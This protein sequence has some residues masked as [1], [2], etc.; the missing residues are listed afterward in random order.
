MRLLG[1]TWCLG[2]GPVSVTQHQFGEKN[3]FDDQKL[4]SGKAE[5]TRKPLKMQFDWARKTKVREYLAKPDPLSLKEEGFD[6][7]YRLNDT[8]C[9][10][11]PYAITPFWETSSWGGTSVTGS[12]QF[13][14]SS[15]SSSSSTSSASS[16]VKDAVSPHCTSNP[17][18][19]LGLVDRDLEQLLSA[20]HMLASAAPASPA[21]SSVG[22]GS[23]AASVGV[24]FAGS[25]LESSALYLQQQ[26]QRVEDLMTKLVSKR[27]A[28]SHPNGTAL[29]STLRVKISPVSQVVGTQ[30]SGE[31]TTQMECDSHA[32]QSLCQDGLHLQAS[33][34]EFPDGISFSVP[35]VGL[36]NL[37]STCYM[38]SVVQC[39][40]ADPSLSQM[41]LHW[42]PENSQGVDPV[43]LKICAELQ[44]IVAAMH[45]SLR[46]S[47]S[48]SALAQ[49]ANIDTKIQQDPHEFY[50]LLSHVVEGIFS[51]SPGDKERISSLI[52]GDMEYV[53]RCTVC[54]ESSLQREPFFEIKLC[55]TKSNTIGDCIKE[56]FSEEAIPGDYRFDRCKCPNLGQIRRVAR[57]TRFPEILNL[58]LVRFSFSSLSRS[59][60]KIMN[61]IAYPGFIDTKALF[62]QGDSAAVHAIYKLFAVV[63]H[64]GKSAQGG[65][66]ITFLLDSKTSHWWQ[67][68]DST[69]TECAGFPP[70]NSLRNETPY[71]LLYHLKET[72]TTTTPFCQAVSEV[73]KEN[74]SLVTQMQE[75]ASLELKEKRA[76]ENCLDNL[77]SCLEGLAAPNTRDYRWISTPWLSSWLNGHSDISPIDNKPLLC[78]HNKVS[79]G[80]H[81]APLRKRIT[82]NMWTFLH[83][84]YN[85]GPELSHDQCCVECLQA[86]LGKKAAS[87]AYK[88]KKSALSATLS[89]CEYG[90]PPRD[91]FYISKKFIDD[92][93]KSRFGARFP[94]QG[95]TAN[96][97]CPHK[98]L[99]PNAKSAYLPVPLDIWQ[100][101]VDLCEG[102][103]PVTL[104]IAN[105]ECAECI[106]ENKLTAEELVKERELIGEMIKHPNDLRLDV[107]YSLLPTEWYVS[108]RSYVTGQSTTK[109]GPLDF[110]CLLCP[111]GKVTMNIPKFVFW[112]MK[113][114]SNYTACSP[115]QL[116]SNEAF[117]RLSTKYGQKGTAISF[118]CQE[119]NQT[120]P[121]NIHSFEPDLLEYTSTP[122][123]CLPCATNYQT[124][125][126]IERAQFSCQD[127]LVKRISRSRLMGWYNSFV[128]YSSAYVKISSSTTVSDL[129]LL[130]L[131]AMEIPPQNQVLKF[132]DEKRI[133]HALDN[134]A[135]SLGEFLVTPRCTIQVED[136]EPQEDSSSSK[137]A[138][139][140]KK[141]QIA[142]EGTGLSESTLS[143]SKAP[144][145]DSSATTSN[146]ISPKQDG[147]ITTSPSTLETAYS[148]LNS[149]LTPSPTT[150]TPDKSVTCT[151][152]QSSAAPPIKTVESITPLS[153]TTTVTIEPHNSMDDDHQVLSTNTN[154]DTAEIASATETTTATATETATTTETGTATT[155]STEPMAVTSTTSES[156]SNNTTTETSIS[157]THEPI[158]LPSEFIGDSEKCSHC[159]TSNLQGS[160]KA[161]HCYNCGR[162]LY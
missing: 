17:N 1:S 161:T 159:G 6:L 103:E 15:T 141:K 128:G 140:H 9:K 78:E 105:G 129:K 147:V 114:I 131:E 38:N 133:L 47:I 91:G 60:V 54:K 151:D 96:I 57:V 155:G 117:M 130:V 56:Y 43:K 84:N 121:L 63:C 55:I 12:A 113:N 97:L 119:F 146:S 3:Q 62:P 19:F 66:Y 154:S 125:K 65:H 132:E 110:T 136:C 127:V 8:V 25:R 112:D 70:E 101:F 72:S 85:G 137:S 134:D 138:P 92:W 23:V 18:C 24:N 13:S 162:S 93:K 145:A 37:G 116:I 45:F 95:L 156:A 21:A 100:Y 64:V 77:D 49:A 29:R 109:P 39:I 42:N 5:K 10:K 149:T 106:L 144:T 74:Q 26:Q 2:V 126:E 98:K 31:L 135:K 80:K 108:W 75:L 158:E 81:L 90:P 7:L 88:E 4:C 71:M 52:T 20:R 94:V 120:P 104:P 46:K 118:T 152:T 51:Q 102:G 41:L 30:K 61:E 58:Q 53:T 67:C 148:E 87:K 79:M 83:S 36:S 111:H 99:L 89:R 28:A 123:V 22:T 11:S 68:N 35:F 86:W 107:P 82:T 150:A 33:S 48:I 32:Q 50:N 59:E 34:L 139:P 27:V 14:F 44:K 142:F 153:E 124:I 73:L 40:S 76:I 160:T 157:V 143:S 69:I 16:G 122:E 115:F